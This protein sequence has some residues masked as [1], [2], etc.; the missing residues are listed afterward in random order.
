MGELLLSQIETY[1]CCHLVYTLS[2][3]VIEKLRKIMAIRNGGERGERREER[4]ESEGDTYIY[5]PFKILERR[6]EGRI[7]ERRE[8][9]TTSLN[10]F[11]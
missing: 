8:R 5:F 7:G 6:G 2:T 3:S 10:P 11:P 1:A 4:G 9:H